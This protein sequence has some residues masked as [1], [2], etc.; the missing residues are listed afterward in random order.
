MSALVLTSY[1]AFCWSSGPSESSSALGWSPWCGFEVHLTA[2][3]PPLRSLLWQ[4]PPLRSRFGSVEEGSWLVLKKR[5]KSSVFCWLSIQHW[6]NSISI[7]SLLVP[8]WGPD[9]PGGELA[10]AHKII[11]CTLLPA[12]L[13]PAPSDVVWLLVG[14]TGE[15]ASNDKI[16]S[17]NVYPV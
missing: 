14:F 5:E 2:S 3:W 10:G 13:Q 16:L 1:S 6:T 17:F 4:W 11:L 12:I 9:P 8:I 15:P 7:S